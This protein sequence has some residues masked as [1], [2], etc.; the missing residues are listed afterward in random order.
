[1]LHLSRLV[2]F[3]VLC[4][5]IFSC[6]SLPRESSKS[7]AN[8]ITDKSFESPDGVVVPIVFQSGN[9]IEP[10]E[11]INQLAFDQQKNIKAINTTRLKYQE[12][13]DFYFIQY[14]TVTL[15][16]QFLTLGLIMDESPSTGV[17]SFDGGCLHTCTDGDCGGTCNLVSVVPCQ[18]T[19]CNCISNDGTCQGTL[20][21]PPKE[22]QK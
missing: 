10:N 20:Q 19:T 16:D 17:L 21:F 15:E 4:L 3:L 1:M 13:G 5:V 22:V 7:E 14:E 2:S 11:V 9:I 8:P 18:S 12:E 6:E